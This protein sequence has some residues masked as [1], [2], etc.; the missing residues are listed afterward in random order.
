M[1]WIQVLVAMKFELVL[2]ALIFALLIIKING[3]ASSGSVLVFA[4]VMLVLNMAVGFFANEPAQLFGEMFHTGGF[5][6]I[7]KS[8]LNLALLIISL[9]SYNWLEKHKHAVEF[10]LLMLSCQLGMFFMLSSGNLL[11]FY[12]PTRRSSQLS[13]RS[14]ARPMA[15]FQ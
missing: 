12:L 6:A 9:F 7:E 8:I 13:P 3:K 14:S 15:V 11:M 2:T 4:N 5:I 10:Y 1:D